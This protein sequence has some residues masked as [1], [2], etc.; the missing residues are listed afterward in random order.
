MPQK[1]A[2]LN[3]VLITTTNSKFNDQNVSDDIR[4]GISEIIISNVGSLARSEGRGA[5]RLVTKCR[6]DKPATPLTNLCAARD[7]LSAAKSARISELHATPA[8]HFI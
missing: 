2:T 1:L 5:V 8:K 7:T 4:S 3:F 6:G